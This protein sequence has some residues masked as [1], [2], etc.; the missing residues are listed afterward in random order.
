MKNRILVLTISLFALLFVGSAKAWN[1]FGHSCAAYIAEQHLTP[2]AKA[3]C[4]HYLQHAFVFYASWMDQWRYIDPYKETSAWHVVY[5]ENEKWQLDTSTAKHAEFQTDRIW[6]EM[7]D[8]KNLPDSLVRQNLIYLIHMVPDFHCPVHTF[9]RNKS[10]AHNDRRY[11]IL[12]KGKKYSNHTFWD[13]SPGFK[14]KNWTMERYAKEVDVI[15]PK[16]A[17]KYQK[18]D[19]IKWAN[20]AIKESNLVYG[21]TPADTEI[22]KLSKGQIAEVHKLSDRMILKGAYRLA[23]IINDIF[24]E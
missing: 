6:R 19:A 12:N 5:V 24:K 10:V 18:G 9:F 7:K 1:G 16:L 17:K 2:E 20:D 3:K 22:T 8:Y 13:A 15:S 21:I 23:Y 11:S 14:R 4:E